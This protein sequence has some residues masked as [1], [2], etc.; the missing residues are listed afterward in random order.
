[1]ILD[2]LDPT[3][4]EFARGTGWTV[5]PEGAC[6]AHLCVPLPA[7]AHQVPGR[8]DVRVVAER[9]G[10]AVVEDPTRGR[11]ALGPES[12]GRALGSAELPEI[13]LPDRHGRPFSLASLRGTK[14][15]LCAWASW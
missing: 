7:E 11:F 3:L 1:M 5:K 2:R 4:D 12:G 10:M 6:K 9:L 15:F 8:I 13:T 14:V